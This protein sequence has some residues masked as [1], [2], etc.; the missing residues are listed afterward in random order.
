[1]YLPLQS[2]ETVKYCILIDLLSRDGLHKGM[3]L[4]VSITHNT[5]I[6]VQGK[7]RGDQDDQVKDSAR[8]HL[9]EVV[10]CEELWSAWLGRPTQT[11]LCGRLSALHQSPVVMR[12]NT[13]IDKVPFLLFG[14]IS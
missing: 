14:E 7:S 11:D 13:K 1:M 2:T 6:G 3:V 4:G 10:W 5:P 9:G 12:S 8:P